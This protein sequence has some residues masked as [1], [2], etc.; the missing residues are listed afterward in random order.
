MSFKILKGAA[1]KNAIAGYGKK[2]ASFSQHTHQLA[3]S[4]LQHVDDHSC[5]SHLN[6]LYASTPTNYRGAI[7][8]WALAFGKVKF[9]AKTLEFTYN[10]KG[11][12]DLESA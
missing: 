10:K 5:T 2:V 1:L 9:D 4:A 11:V 7:R 6:A 8:V 3:Y 12:S